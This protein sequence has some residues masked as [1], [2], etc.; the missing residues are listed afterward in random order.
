MKGANFKL[1][2]LPSNSFNLRH[3]YL[4]F[5]AFLFKYVHIQRIDE[6]NHGGSMLELE[7][8]ADQRVYPNAG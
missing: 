7:R 6:N 5:N 1:K 4:Q 2:Q 3:S 8:V